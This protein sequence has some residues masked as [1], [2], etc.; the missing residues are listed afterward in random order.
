VFL[1]TSFL[2]TVTGICDKNNF[3]GA[4]RYARC[5]KKKIKFQK[6]I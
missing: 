6:V 2:Q 1:V 5:S 4:A 3:Y